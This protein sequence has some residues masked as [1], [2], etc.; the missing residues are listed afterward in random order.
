M[1]KQ[2]LFIFLLP[3]WLTAETIETFYGPM[4]VDEPVL[5]E[6]IHHPAVQRL[7]KI[8]QYGISFYTTPFNE[9]YNR[10]DHSIGVFAILRHYNA[11]LKEQIAGLL[12]DVSHTVFSHV[13]DWIFGKENQE[14]DYQSTIHSLFLKKSGL[15]TV[16]EKYQIRVEEIIPLEKYFP[17][18]E[19]KGPKL[20]A[21]RIDYNI[22]GAY[23][24]GF[25]THDEALV[26]FKKFQFLDGAWIHLESELMKK[27]VY[28][29]LYMSEN[30]WGSADN[31]FLSKNLAEAILRGVELDIISYDEIHHGTDDDI[32]EKL[33]FSCDP[34]IE[35]K[36]KA[37]YYPQ[38]HYSLVDDPLEADMIVR[39]KFRGIDP[40][41]LYNGQIRTLTSL[42]ALL[43]QKYN[44]TMENMLRGWPIKAY[45]H[46][47]PL[48][49][50]AQL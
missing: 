7:K 10:Y 50:L 6:L 19:Q 40:F 34:F 46:T 27:L 36:L 43:N 2:L 17:M 30:C 5:I 29:S 25:I 20:C 37:L 11:S 12:H 23:Y 13:G 41:V 44:E 26:L 9:N 35:A 1:S 8:H 28:F 21:D 14:A 42:D 49:D 33:T 16:L 22:Q 24:Q 4:E 39:S 32:W 48:M 47:A 3:F 31:H 45:S 15:A 38:Q 18:L